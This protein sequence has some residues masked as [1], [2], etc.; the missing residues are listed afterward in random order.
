MELS[1]LYYVL[2]F[3]IGLTAFLYLPFLDKFKRFAVDLFDKSGWNES[4]QRLSLILLGILLILC[5]MSYTEV[6]SRSNVKLDANNLSEYVRY[7]ET[8]RDCILCFLTLAFIPFIYRYYSKLNEYY[9]QS[10]LEQGA[11]RQAENQ[12]ITNMQM[13]QQMENLNKEIQKLKDAKV[14]KIGG[15]GSKAAS[16]SG[17]DSKAKEKQ[18]QTVIQQKNFELDKQNK[19]LQEKL[20]KATKAVKRLKYQIGDEKTKLSKLNSK[21]DDL[22]EKVEDI[23]SQLHSGAAKKTR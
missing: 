11:R 22:E 1:F 7:V 16:K 15:T 3:E 10:I 17:K 14:N 13:A 20:E 23:N 6:Q 12:S 18:Q 8:Q 5:Y 19:E 2:Y 4:F 9:R 21:K